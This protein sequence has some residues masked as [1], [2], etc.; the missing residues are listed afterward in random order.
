[1]KTGQG[2]SWAVEATSKHAVENETI[3]N[4]RLFKVAIE[5]DM[6]VTRD[7]PGALSPIDS[8]ENLSGNP[9]QG[10]KVWYYLY[11]MS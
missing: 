4:S 6:W 10:T 7:K 8:E 9:G 11:K 3:E 1:M 2:I 5:Y